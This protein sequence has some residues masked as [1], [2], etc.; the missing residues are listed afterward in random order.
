MSPTRP[1][2]LTLDP[3]VEQ[4]ILEDRATHTLSPWRT[5]DAAV[6]RRDDFPHDAA[7]LTRPAFVRDIE[8][9]L[10]I[11]AYNRYAD[12]TQV[13]SFVQ[14]D[15]ISR[16]GLHVQ[17]VSRIARGIGGLL[18]LNCD[19]I[20]AIALGHDVGHTPFGHAGER[21]LS[22]CYHRR[23]GRYFNHNVH[24]V[25]VLDELY[26]RNISLQ[27]L[28][29]VLCHNGEFAQQVLRVGDTTSFEQL[30]RLVAAC[31]ADEQAIKTLRP[32]TLEGCVVRVSDMIAYIGKDRQDALAMG[33]LGDYGAFD[34]DV[35]GTTNAR[36]INN[37]TV[38]IVNNSY[39]QDRIA[40]SEEVFCDLKAAKR[41]NYEVIYLKEGMVDE[42]ENIVE[43][44]FEDMYARLLDDLV[45][46]R[47]DSPIFRHHV[48]RLC[49]QSRSITPEGYLAGEPNQIVVDYMA[50]MT[51][52]YF[53]AIY[54]HLFPGSTR[55]IQTRG[56]CA[57]L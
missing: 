48:K 52:S 39:G 26:R 44:M 7:T 56:Y 25:R 16:R 32:T 2:Y 21:F 22:A 40:L 11:P 41:Q 51:D 27:T 38:D 47:E 54:E 50:S 55:R 18:G 57:D 29:G 15:E 53:V 14:N 45:A 19:L 28:D 31:N 37:L 20:E 43:E 3:L 1:A 9:V 10:N 34:S 33:V 49:A 4:A 36:I 17:L 30:D 13:F 8:K 6:V 46:G 35:I 23:T 42:T 24:S 5:P 12:K